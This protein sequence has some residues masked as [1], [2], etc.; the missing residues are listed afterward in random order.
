MSPSIL[1]LNHRHD[2]PVDGSKYTINSL[3]TVWRQMGLSVLFQSGLPP[4]RG[5][6]ADIAV[7]HV[8]STATPAR[9]LRYL[10]R[11]P[12][13]LNG[14]LVDTSKQLYNSD[15]LSAGDAYDGPVIVK[16]T[17]NSGGANEH[18]QAARLSRYFGALLRAPRRVFAPASHWGTTARVKSRDYPVYDRPSLVPPEVW[19]NPNL[20]VQKFQP[21][22]EGD[23]LYRLRSWYLLG[24]QGFHVVTVAKQPIVKGVNIVDRWVANDGTPTELTEVRKKMRVDYGRFD[25]VMV[26]GKG[27]V[28]EINRTPKNSPEAAVKYAAQWRGLAEG[29]SAFLG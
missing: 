21:E 28:Y 9:Y 25:Y 26:G 10:S 5:M 29:I 27:V 13:V 18:K 1:I 17:L 3:L 11:Y 12:T 22:L 7:N 20:L 14:G 2:S 16:T 8:C 15:L 19:T 24:D 4:L 6:D 23:G